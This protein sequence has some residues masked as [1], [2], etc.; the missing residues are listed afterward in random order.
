MQSRR[1]DPARQLEVEWRVVGIF[2]WLR[3]GD[4]RR[5]EPRLR[6][7][8]SAIGAA[9]HRDAGT[10]DA[11]IDDGQLPAEQLPH[12]EVC[13]DILRR[14]QR[15]RLLVVGVAHDEILD[16]QRQPTER[17]RG[18][19][20][21]HRQAGKPGAEVREVFEEQPQ[22]HAGNQASGGQTFGPSPPPTGLAFALGCFG[23]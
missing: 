10:R 13:D 14:Q 23:L 20:P 12:R 15:W 16:V 2:L 17:Q 3:H 19:A 6:Q 21:R 5:L 8:Q 4:R 22:Q 11:G 18:T 1:L 9:M 7:T